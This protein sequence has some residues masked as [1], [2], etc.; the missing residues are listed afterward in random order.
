M[1]ISLERNGAIYTLHSFRD[2]TITIRPPNAAPDDEEKLSI[3]VE[4]LN[5]I[6]ACVRHIDVAVGVDRQPLEIGRAHV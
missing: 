5:R 4:D 2:A 3:L 6:E 1:K